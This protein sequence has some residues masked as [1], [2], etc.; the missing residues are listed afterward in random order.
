MEGGLI[1]AK[2]IDDV[3]F[4]YEP[5]FGNL[6]EVYITDIH[7]NDYILAEINLTEAEMQKSYEDLYNL[8]LEI[9]HDLGYML[10]GEYEYISS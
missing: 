4:R 1:I 3:W 6:M 7:G 8:C 5:E 9:A 2:I 10:I